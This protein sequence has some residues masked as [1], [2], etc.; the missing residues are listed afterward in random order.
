MRFRLD[1]PHL[2]RA[3]GP[4]ITSAS[5]RVSYN[6]GITWH[7]ADR[8]RIDR[9]T[10]QVRVDNPSVSKKAYAT[11]QVKA[12]DAAGNAVTERINRAYVVP[13]NPSQPAARP[14]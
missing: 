10:Y 12:T 3:A 14:V 5:L 11:I 6:G 9:D 1:L 13:A 8:S 2:A 4:K 7:S